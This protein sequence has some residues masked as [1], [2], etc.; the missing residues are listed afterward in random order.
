MTRSEAALS[1]ESYLEVGPGGNFLSTSHTIRHFAEANY[2]SLLPDAG[3]FETWKENGSLTADRRANA[4]WKRMLDTYEPP[5]L[6][7]A[8]RRR[9]ETFVA[10]RKAAMP[11]EWH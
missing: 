10:S 11:D 2:E 7:Q 8:V 6:D 5:Q 4:V 3:P 9:L 1:P